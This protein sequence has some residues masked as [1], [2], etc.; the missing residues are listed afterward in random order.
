MSNFNNY[1]VITGGPGVGKTTLLQ[2]LSDCGFV[3]VPEDARQ[4]IREQVDSDGDAL[5]WENRE[6]Y[7]YLMFEASAES[8][9]KTKAR[10]KD[11]VFF[12]RSIIDAVCYM[13]MEAISLDNDMQKTV[14]SC[15]YN[16]TVFLLPPW[17]EIFKADKE[18]KQTW[19]EAILTYEQLKDAY[20]D[21]G[22][23]V[24]EVRRGSVEERKDFVLGIINGS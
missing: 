2:H 13:K 20:K 7:A 18:R 9:Q 15:R 12:D 16:K 24:V 22:Y 21:A 17:K 1:Y 6:K 4:I 5:P 14:K 23:E 3:I 11:L 10:K 19:Y 8:Y